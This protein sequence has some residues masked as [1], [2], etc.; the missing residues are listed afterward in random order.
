R[1]ARIAIE[2]YLIARR[3][4][5]DQRLVP[6]DE[7]A[8]TQARIFGFFT[9]AVRG[10]R[11]VQQLIAVGL[12]ISGRE[13]ADILLCPAA[14]DRAGP[15]L[16]IARGAYQLDIAVVARIALGACDRAGRTRRA[17]TRLSD[18]AC[19]NR[20]RRLPGHSQRMLRVLRGRTT[21]RSSVTPGTDRRPAIHEAAGCNSGCRPE[22]CAKQ[23][24]RKS[25]T[26]GAATCDSSRITSGTRA[27]WL[28]TAGI[29]LATTATFSGPPTG[30]AGHGAGSP[31]TA[32]RCT[33]TSTARRVAGE[34]GQCGVST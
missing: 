12:Q 20:A 22:P 21:S 26:V 15:L 3:I 10:E 29:V 7:K 5:A 11:Q 16:G 9:I 13:I 28:S 17:S 33:S 6:V 31:P 18:E 8:E 4:D 19:G 32:D 30:T 2:V 27:P 25:W 23:L 14:R 1:H 24:R 34:I